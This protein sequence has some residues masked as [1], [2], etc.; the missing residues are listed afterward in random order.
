MIRAHLMNFVGGAVAGS[1]DPADAGLETHRE[2][3]RAILDAYP[4]IAPSQLVAEE[5]RTGHPLVIAAG[6]GTLTQLVVA[7]ASRGVRTEIA[8]PTALQN[9]RHTE[10]ELL[11]ARRR[12]L[13]TG[14]DIE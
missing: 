7:V 2:R 13:G 3:S 12:D 1:S 10:L 8:R 6:F 9:R 4:E 14:G 11:Q 5:V